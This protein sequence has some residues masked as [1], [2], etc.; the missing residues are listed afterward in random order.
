MR[1]SLDVALN[2]TTSGF[3]AHQSALKHDEL[4]KIPQYKLSSAQEKKVKMTERC[5]LGRSGG[6]AR[7]QKNCRSLDA[8]LVF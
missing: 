8:L 3:V 1:E 5:T 4:L 2:M 7:Q 6:A